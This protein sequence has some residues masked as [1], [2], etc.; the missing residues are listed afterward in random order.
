MENLKEIGIEEL[1]SSEL[2]EIQGGGWL[3]KLI[4]YVIGEC[5]EGFQ[6]GLSKPCQPCP[7]EVK[8]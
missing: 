2:C 3:D 8:C 1:K 4:G 6:N 5:I 7:E